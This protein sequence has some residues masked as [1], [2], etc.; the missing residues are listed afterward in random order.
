LWKNLVKHETHEREVLR[1]R[2]NSG[3]KVNFGTVVDGLKRIFLE[4]INKHESQQVFLLRN[5]G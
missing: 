4:F 1:K 5:E 3:S 2:R